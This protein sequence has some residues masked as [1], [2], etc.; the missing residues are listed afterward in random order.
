MLFHSPHGT[1]RLFY[2]KS[3][4][5][6]PGRLQLF[7]QNCWLISFQFISSASEASAHVVAIF[8]YFAVIKATWRG[9]RK[10]KDE[11]MNLKTLPSSNDG[12][13]ASATLIEEKYYR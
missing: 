5:R 7:D 6:E 3:P 2:F 9:K 8:S 10:Q 4:T 13:L 1:F 12:K 11:R